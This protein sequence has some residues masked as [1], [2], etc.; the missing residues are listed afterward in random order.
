MSQPRTDHWAKMKHTATNFVVKMP[1]AVVITKR[2]NIKCR[3]F[4][5]SLSRHTILS[6]GQTGTLVDRQKF[7][8][9]K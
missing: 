5:P 9:K 3:G 2:K 1:E 6:K 8:P 4:H 7:V